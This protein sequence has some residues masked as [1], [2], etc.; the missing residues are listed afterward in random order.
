MERFPTQI[1]RDGTVLSVKLNNLS[2]K[3]LKKFGKPVDILEYETPIGQNF[4]VL[5]S[6]TLQNIRIVH[7][8]D[9]KDKF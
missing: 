9:M 8:I 4:L 3:K 6:V 7:V 5:E 1:Y 2:P